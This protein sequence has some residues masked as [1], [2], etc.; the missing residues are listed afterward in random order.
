[1][2][3]YIFVVI[4]FLLL[5]ELVVRSY[6]HWPKLQL[7]N[8]LQPPL[9]IHQHTP[10]LPADGAAAKTGH[11]GLE[12]RLAFLSLALA[13]EGEDLVVKG[14]GL[15]PHGGDTEV[16]GL[17]ED[18][19]GDGGRGDD[20]D[21]RVPGVGQGGEGGHGGDLLVA[22]RGHGDGGRRG[23]DGDGGDVVVEIPGED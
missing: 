8:C 2:H 7:P 6:P 10:P 18:L 11:D 17:L 3:P 20:G 12:A 16:L 13:G 21:G 23:V 5:W 22:E 14:A 9:P 15:Q 19:A 4:N 1:M